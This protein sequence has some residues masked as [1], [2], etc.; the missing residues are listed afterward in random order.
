MSRTSH[1]DPDLKSEVIRE[2]EVG[3]WCVRHVIMVVYAHTYVWKIKLNVL[4]VGINLTSYQRDRDF[5][6]QILPNV[7]PVCVLSRKD[8]T[9]LYRIVNPHFIHRRKRDTL[10]LQTSTVTLR[11]HLF[12]SFLLL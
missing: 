1:I 7:V 5:V 10:S 8:C 3:T 12:H 6:V 9:L 11:S 2:S 4:Y